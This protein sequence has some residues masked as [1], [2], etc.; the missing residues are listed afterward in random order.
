M[1]PRQWTW[2]QRAGGRSITVIRDRSATAIFWCC[3]CKWSCYRSDQQR[4]ASGAL[5]RTKHHLHDLSL[6]GHYLGRCITTSISLLFGSVVVLDA[7]DSVHHLK[8]D[9]VDGVFNHDIRLVKSGKPMPVN[10]AK[11]ILL[12]APSP[13]RTHHPSSI[14][15]TRMSHLF[16]PF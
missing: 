15:M 16:R 6:H 2:L 10:Y 13:S 3:H 8:L 14:G 1:R 11:I 12:P 4:R 9:G 7:K 5:A